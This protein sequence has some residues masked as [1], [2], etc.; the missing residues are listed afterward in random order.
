MVLVPRINKNFIKSK[1]VPNQLIKCLP[2]LVVVGR[3]RSPLRT[4][5]APPFAILG[6]Q[7]SIVD[8]A[9]LPLLE[10]GSLLPV[11]RQNLVTSLLVTY[12]VATLRSS[13]VVYLKMSLCSPKRGFRVQH[14]GHVLAS[15]RQA[16]RRA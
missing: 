2:L 9:S 10:V 1:N 11:G 14:S 4:L 13:L 3:G 12:Q 7:P 8:G 6:A 16:Y 5:L 15:P